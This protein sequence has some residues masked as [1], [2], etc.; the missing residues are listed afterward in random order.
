MP[1]PFGARRGPGRLLRYVRD[2]FLNHWNLLLFGGA[3]AAALISPV[4]EAGL[5]LAVAGE[6]IY[7]GG[8]ATNPRYQS[9]VDRKLHEAS[10]AVASPGDASGRSEVDQLLASLPQASRDRFM[11]LKSRCLDLLRLAARMRGAADA[12]ADASTPTLNQMLYVFL[13]LLGS[14]AALDAFL[15]KTDEG[16]L[17]GEVADLERRLAAPVLDERIRQALTDSLVTARLRRD[18]LATARTNRELVEIQL[19]RIEGQ[20]QAIAETS[21]SSEDPTFITARLES[22]GLGASFESLAALEAV[23][24]LKHLASADA[25]AILELAEADG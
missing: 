10:R 23:P 11:R 3:A 25:P 24:G 22:H 18:N 13:R 6:L 2:A 16:R 4:P 8:L 21:I 14:E 12:P 15:E 7:L 5:A 1:E 17:T 20:L 9:W 19:N